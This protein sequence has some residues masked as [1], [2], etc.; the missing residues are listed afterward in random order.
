[1]AVTF[2]LTSSASATEWSGYAAA[3]GHLFA[4]LPNFRDQKRHNASVA[5]QP[6][7]YNEWDGGRSFTFVPFFR[8]DSADSERTHFDIRELFGLWVFETWEL[9]VGIRK[10]FW[11]VTESQHLVDIINQT[12]SVESPDGEEKLGQPMVNISL[13]RDWGT[14]DLFIMPYFRERTFIGREGRL[15]NALIVDSDQAIFES[16][17]EE[18]HLDIAARYSHTIGDWDVGV[19]HFRGTGRDPTLLSGTD[20]AGN[21]VWVPFYEQI[22]QTGLDVQ[23]ITGEWLW[24]LETIYRSGQGDSFLALTGGFEYTLV[25]IA[26][27]GMDLGIIGEWLYDDRDNSSPSPF[28]NDVMI[29]LRLAVNDPASTEALLGIIQDLGSN[30]R[31]LSIESSRR[32]SDHL[33]ANLEMRAYLDQPK[34][35]IFFDLRDDDFVKIE[36]AYYF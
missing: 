35:D 29:G 17:A 34:D 20:S 25:A 21:S 12:D 6:E 18:Y 31:F 33:K 10:V 5:L 4:N 30:T 28:E 27:S 19:S 32:L 22:N 36:L 26:R 15:R 16:G 3:E 9:G 7:Y 11:G 23:W 1:M 13:P 14:I 2:L 8:L 24:K